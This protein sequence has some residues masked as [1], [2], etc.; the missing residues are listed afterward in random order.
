[1][2]HFHV[3]VAN[4][5]GQ[6]VPLGVDSSGRLTTEAPI[7]R[8]CMSSN[9]AVS[10]VTQAYV[11]AGAVQA[12]ECLDPLATTTL[13]VTD[14][15]VQAAI[16]WQFDG[17]VGLPPLLALL[18]PVNEVIG[19]NASECLSGTEGADA[20][21]GGGGNDLLRGLGGNDFLF[22]EGGNDVL[23]GGLGNDIMA[24]GTGN[25]VYKV[26]SA[27]DNVIET[28]NEGWD[29][30]LTSLGA[31]TLGA[32]VEALSFTGTGSFAGTGNDGAN[33]IIGGSRSDT[34]SGA[35]GDDVLAGLAGNDRLIGGAG[36]D[37]M[38]GGLGNDTFVFSAG[39]GKDR[40]QD[41]DANPRGGQDLIELSGFGITASTFAERVAITDIGAD[42]LVTVDGADTTIRLVG[43]GN[44]KTVGID[45][46]FFAA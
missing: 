29:G 26:D 5:A 35:G 13:H 38:S 40:I 4:S 16:N 28:T 3:L 39:F 23:D 46:F 7:K 11:V 44:A 33:A 42:T 36:N 41:F 37:T 6:F 8:L 25:D 18:S 19:T 20:M 14:A 27:G 21:H 2:E 10:I 32:N 12:A 31:Y 17:G 22:G 34:L 45:D 1:M 43:I 30:V 9:A 24:G 15:Q